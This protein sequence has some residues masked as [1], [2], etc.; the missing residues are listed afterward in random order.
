MRF[1]ALGHT[2]ILCMVC[3]AGCDQTT[4]DADMARAVLQQRKQQLA[5]VFMPCPRNS[6]TVMASLVSASQCL[7]F[8]VPENPALP[9]GK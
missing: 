9:Q 2:L 3:I 4:R 8:E 1:S 5:D 7:V 6:T